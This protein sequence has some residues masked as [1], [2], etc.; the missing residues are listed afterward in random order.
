MTSKPTVSLAL[1]DTQATR[2]GRATGRGHHAALG[3]PDQVVV[4]QPGN[5]ARLRTE[6]IDGDAAELVRIHQLERHGAR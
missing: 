4:R 3:L 6:A 5:A 2:L 1:A